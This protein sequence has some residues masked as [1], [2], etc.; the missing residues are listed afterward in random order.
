MRTPSL[1]PRGGC[2]VSEYRV[3]AASKRNPARDEQE[4]GNNVEKHG[5][6][7][8]DRLAVHHE[9]DSGEAR[10]LCKQEIRLQSNSPATRLMPPSPMTKK[11]SGGGRMTCFL[12]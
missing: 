4:H 2:C 7:V 1:L 6:C 3:H 11:M 8:I 10:E 9:I 12:E 5:R